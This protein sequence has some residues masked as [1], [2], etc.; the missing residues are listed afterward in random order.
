MIITSV[1]NPIFAD[2]DSKSVRCAVTFDSLSGPHAYTAADGDADS[3]SLFNSL[4]AG[5][6]GAVAAFVAAPPASLASLKQAAVLAA[7]A[8]ADEVV[9]QVTTTITRQA[10]FQ[11]AAGIIAGNGGTAPTSGPYADTFAAL[12]LS[13]GK[14]ASDFAVVV[15]TMQNATLQ[16]ETAMSNFDA[17]VATKSTTPQIVLAITTFEHALSAVILQVN[18][19]TPNSVTTPPPIFIPGVTA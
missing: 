17:E 15:F 12:A 16:I 11:N 9:K 8:Y 1:S 10:A 7:S 19:V 14:S 4:I 6:H 18:A 13:Y 3:Q 2:A 5:D